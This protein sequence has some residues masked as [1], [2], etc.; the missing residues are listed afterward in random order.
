MNRRYTISPVLYVAFCLLSKAF[1]Q[2]T[3]PAGTNLTSLCTQEQTKAAGYFLDYLKT[4]DD[5]LYRS[6]MFEQFEILTSAE[7]NLAIKLNELISSLGSTLIILPI[8]TKP[9]I[10]FKEANFDPR[11]LQASYYEGIELLLKNNIAVVDLLTPALNHYIDENTGRVFNDKYDSH[12]GS[13]G[14]ELSV[15]EL[16]N[17]LHSIKSFD[18]L[19]RHVYTLNPASA[20]GQNNL[21]SEI[22]QK[23][24]VKFPNVDFALFKVSRKQSNDDLLTDEELS[25]LALLGTS[26]SKFLQFNLSGRIEV[27]T[28]VDVLDYSVVGGGKSS[29]LKTFLKD[30]AGK[31]ILPRFIIW[32]FPVYQKMDDLE[33]A[34]LIKILNSW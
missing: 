14:V 15:K 17:K 23:C 18:Q 31:Q 22:D 24:R 2:G 33:A 7:L 13:Y 27:A 10:S 6:S 4:P 32:E 28:G 3:I 5:W 29:A 9:I 11:E 30:F 8:P 19:P 34:A 20:R 1:A 21:A 25:P 16:V 26:Y 12:W